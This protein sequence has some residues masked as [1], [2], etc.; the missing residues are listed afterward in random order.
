MVT[1]ECHR[2]IYGKWS[3]ALRHFDGIQLGLT[4]TPCTADTD[5]LPDPEDGLFIRDTLQFFEL[6]QP[7]FRYTLRQA[8]QEAHL[9]PYRIYRARTVKTAAREGF[10]VKR[11]ELELERH[12][13][14][15]A[16]RIRG[17]LCQDSNKIRIMV[18]EQGI[19][20]C[21]PSGR[22]RTKR[23]PSSKRLYKMGHKV[24]NLFPSSRT[25]DAL[26]PAT[27]AVPMSSSLPS[28][29]PQPSSSGDES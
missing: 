20:P 27:T 26:P 6:D 4:A 10:T 17:S 28:S 14:E 2:S 24:E 3:A 1:D 8:T 15:D 23:L 13:P 7:T 22:N 18:L 9:V 25:G 29:W 19:T 11:A 5:M 21:I 16:G 12:G